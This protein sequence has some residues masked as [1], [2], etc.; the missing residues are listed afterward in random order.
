MRNLILSHIT[1]S[2]LVSTYLSLLHSLLVTSGL[3]RVVCSVCV[4]E[5]LVE[6]SSPQHLPMYQPDD[7][8]GMDSLSS[9]LVNMFLSVFT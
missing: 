6:G 9:A 1:S 8:S 7:V 5:Y 3:C 4:C 2:H